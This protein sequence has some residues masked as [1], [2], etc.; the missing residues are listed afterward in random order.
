MERVGASSSFVDRRLPSDSRMIFGAIVNIIDLKVQSDWHNRWH[1]GVTRC[2]IIPS[3]K[4]SNNAFDYSLTGR[5][6]LNKDE[7]IY[8]HFSIHPPRWTSQRLEYGHPRAPPT[9]NTN[10]ADVRN[11]SEPPSTC[12]VHPSPFETHYRPTGITRQLHTV[13]FSLRG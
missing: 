10:Q 2:S 13:Q 6:H 5:K 3:E 11:V 9:S 12:P 8:Q 4:S 7:G 1:G